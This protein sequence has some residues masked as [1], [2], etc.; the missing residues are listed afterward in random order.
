MELTRPNDFEKPRGMHPESN[1]HQS[2]LSEKKHS[3][4]C[5]PLMEEEEFTPSA[6]RLPFRSLGAKVLYHAL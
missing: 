5:D 1:L 4:Q 6:A 3:S 2:A